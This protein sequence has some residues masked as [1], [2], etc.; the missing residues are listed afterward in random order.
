MIKIKQTVDD[1]KIRANGWVQDSSDFDHLWWFCSA[2]DKNSPNF[3]AILKKIDLYVTPDS[4]KKSLRSVMLSSK[5]KYHY[6]Q[7]VGNHK[8]G[9]SRKTST[10]CNGIGQAAVDGQKRPFIG[11]WPA[12]NFLRWALLLGFVQYLM[13]TDEYQIS[14]LGKSFVRETDV[15]KRNKIVSTA[16]KNYPPVRR[17]IRLLKDNPNGMTKF[18]IGEKLGCVGEKG[19]TNIGQKLFE[20]MYLSADS[21]MKKS[22]MSD[23]EGSSDKYARQICSWLQKLNYIAIKKP[24]DKNKAPLNVYYLTAFGV[25]FARQI[26]I[27][28][29]INVQFSM[30]SMASSNKESIMKRR[31]M[32]LY[33]VQ[34]KSVNNIKD[35]ESKLNQQSIA[36]NSYEL[37]DDILSMNRC[38]IDIQVKA[39][40]IDLKDYVDGL[41]IPDKISVGKSTIIEQIKEFLRPQLKHINHDLLKLIDFSYGGKESFEWFENYTYQVFSCFC[42]NAQWLGGSSRPDVIAE[43]GQ[44]GLII[45][46][47][48]YKSGFSADRSLKDEMIRYVNEADQKP[49]NIASKWW[50]KF[51]PSV[52]RFAFQYVSTSFSKEIGRQLSDIS[53][54]SYSK[55]KGSAISAQNLLLLAEKALTSGIDVSIFESNSEI[56]HGKHF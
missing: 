38:G 4:L 43:Y 20:E 36:S 34:E 56:Q 5:Q 44:L 19:F 35:L 9:A 15:F 53:E 55:E 30:L 2:F 49:E 46:S 8:G 17:I 7:I 52:S 47:K 6:F 14:E 41:D 27:S 1:Y 28:K 10:V 32:I 51:S 54:H 16:L 45:D 26:E 23:K 50:E 22:L 33:F 37:E 12:D 48:A 29:T 25:D 42:S 3:E 18:E 40:A 11:D 24:I 39:G 13:D 21:Q 31:A